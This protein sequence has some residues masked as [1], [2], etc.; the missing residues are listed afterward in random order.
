MVQNGTDI[1]LL[2]F[3]TDWCKLILNENLSTS[4][5]LTLTGGHSKR[6]VSDFEK[7][8]QDLKGKLRVG[9]VDCEEE[10]VLCETFD[11]T[12]IPRFYFVEG[13]SKTFY[14]GDRNASSLLSESLNRFNEKEKR[15][16]S[17]AIENNLIE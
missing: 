3:Y 1:W 16:N 15:K 11:I 9:A 14:I 6:F 7:L 2:E 8:A 5:F 13:N 10:E 12:H 17:T 4:S